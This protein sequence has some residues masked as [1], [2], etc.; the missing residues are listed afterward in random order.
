MRCFVKI[1]LMGSVGSLVGC[2]TLTEVAEQSSA[3]TP[4][5]TIKK[6]TSDLT[7]RQEYFLGRSIAA[8]VLSES[9]AIA[10][11]PL[12]AYL[13]E[14]GQYLALHSS[15]PETFL[16]YRFVATVSK[17]PF[18]LSAPGGFVLVSSGM[19]K[20]VRNE[21]ELAA[22][23]AHEIAHIAA[24]HA[25]SNIQAAN[26]F[27]LGE[28][29]LDILAAVSPTAS[30]LASFGKIV[31]DSINMKFNQ[32]QE[33]EADAEAV[34]ILER[35]GYS[36]TA[37]LG[38]IKRIPDDSSARSSHP[39]SESRLRELLR[40][41]RGEKYTLNSM[42]QKRFLGQMRAISGPKSVQSR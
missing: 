19:L 15:R 28:Q 34:Q 41:G 37:L 18:A 4:F 29:F 30:A 33:L 17:V 32:E 40:L 10:S 27:K 31:A 22:I 24:R 20:I 14:L 21:D 26:R 9:P 7:P 12:Q 5:R 38:V 25:E 3:N 39:A 35:A 42:R 11:Q 2:T 1:F 16:G 6:A 36:A 23:F 13:N 8:T